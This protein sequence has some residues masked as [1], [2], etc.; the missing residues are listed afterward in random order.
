MS[1]VS[2]LSLSLAAAGGGGGG[3]DANLLLW[4]GAGAASPAVSLVHAW[5]VRRRSASILAGVSSTVSVDLVC[6]I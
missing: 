3:S 2:S 4:L 5:L 1:T 6:K